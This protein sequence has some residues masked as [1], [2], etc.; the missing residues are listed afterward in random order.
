MMGKTEPVPL[1]N[2]R[3]G[4]EREDAKEEMKE[5]ISLYTFC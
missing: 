1:T 3:L 2:G 4:Q 5:N